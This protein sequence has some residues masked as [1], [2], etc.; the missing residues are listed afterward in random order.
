M[1][2]DRLASPRGPA[3]DSALRAPETPSAQG[4][5]GQVGAGDQQSE[6]GSGE[7]S[8]GLPAV[9]EARVFIENTC[10]VRPGVAGALTLVGAEGGK[11][12]VPQSARLRPRLFRS[13]EDSGGAP[14]PLWGEGCG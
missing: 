11:S 12:L 4:T 10:L 14:L 3:S 13:R 5:P 1:R 7:G 9:G 8:P 6:Q 2:L